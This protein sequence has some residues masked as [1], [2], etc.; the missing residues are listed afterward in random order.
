MLK[1]DWNYRRGDIYLVDLGEHR[2]NIQ[3]KV[4][5]VINIQNNSGNF[6]GPT[7]IVVPLTTELKKLEQPTHYVLQKQRGLDK[8]SMMDIIPSKDDVIKKKYLVAGTDVCGY[9][10]GLEFASL[11]GLTTQVPMQTE[12]VTNKATRRVR[13]VSVGGFSVK[14][15]KPRTFINQDNYCAMQLLDL[16]N[17]I[18]S[19]SELTGRELQK[20]ISDYMD[21]IGLEFCDLLQYLD[22][23]PDK[24]YKNLF[25]VGVLYGISA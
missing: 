19:L 23:Y 4:R 16:V 10:S 21:N 18:D 6:F 1:K 9:I 12:V 11:L 7:L 24:I 14:L 3:G 15:R 22:L 25:E 13:E 8:T 5:P 20:A 17:D 2:G